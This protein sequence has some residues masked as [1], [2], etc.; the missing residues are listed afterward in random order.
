MTQIAQSSFVIDK[1]DAVPVEWEG[2]NMGHN[3]FHKTFSGDITGTSLVKAI[4]LVN[5]NS[6]PAVYVG[7][8]RFH[9]SVHGK[10]GTFL[11]TH[12]A[13]MPDP[14]RITRWQIVPG[15]GT[16]EL[17]G[18]SGTGEIQP[19]HNFRMEYNLDNVGTTD[20]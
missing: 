20:A 19:G 10:Q 2:G 12:T 14:E 7:V 11:L 9:C 3:S 16:G 17:A 15:S 18:I 6:G 5:E 13:F 1:K 8:E 4:M